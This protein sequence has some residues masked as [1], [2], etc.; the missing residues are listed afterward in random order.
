MHRAHVIAVGAVLGL[1]LPVAVI[2]VGRGAPQDLK[3][4]GR[5]VHDQVDDFR[6]FPEV[7][8]QRHDIR[9]EAAEQEA[10]I[11]AEARDFRQVV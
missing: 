3:T 5:L 7:L 4:L 11:R 2:D 1:Q 9:I 6:R 8:D 10:T